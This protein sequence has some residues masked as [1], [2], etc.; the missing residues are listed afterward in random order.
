[1]AKKANGSVNG[2][3]RGS[4]AAGAV[5]V[6]RLQKNS[7]TLGDRQYHPAITRRAHNRHC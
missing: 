6:V 5:W 2:S 4:D 3:W 7:V 1:M